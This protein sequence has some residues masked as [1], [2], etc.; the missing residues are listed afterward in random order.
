M[1]NGSGGVGGG[2]SW[3]GS[4]DGLFAGTGVRGVGE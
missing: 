4:H 2:G 3:L 1:A